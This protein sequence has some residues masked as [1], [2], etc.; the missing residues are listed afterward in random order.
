MMVDFHVP[1]EEVPPD[2]FVAATFTF[3]PCPCGCGS[4]KLVGFDAQGVARAMFAIEP[5]QVAA[6]AAM[7]CVCAGQAPNGQETKH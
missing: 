6:M 5:Y 2:C 4:F 3:G 7:L 1:R